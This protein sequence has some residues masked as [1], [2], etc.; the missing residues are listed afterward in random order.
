M[1]CSSSHTAIKMAK[2]QKN[3]VCVW[4]GIP[5]YTTKIWKG[6]QKKTA[7]FVQQTA[8]VTQLKEAPRR[9]HGKQENEITSRTPNSHKLHMAGVR[10]GGGLN[11]EKTLGDEKNGHL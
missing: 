6:H 5:I 8:Q 9:P 1:N 2:E 4:G 3:S 7:R 10:Q 11:K